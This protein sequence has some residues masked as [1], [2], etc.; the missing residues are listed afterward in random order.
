MIPIQKREKLIPSLKKDWII[1]DQRKK[2]RQKREKEKEKGR[3]ELLKEGNV[4]NCYEI[5][6]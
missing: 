1:K 3:T 2:K 5:V 6:N 4:N